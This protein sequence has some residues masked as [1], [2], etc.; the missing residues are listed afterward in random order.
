MRVAAQKAKRRVSRTKTF[1]APRRGWIANENLASSKPEGS[2]LLQNWFPTPTGCRARGGSEKYGTAEVDEPVTSMATYETGNSSEFFAT[3]AT[4]LYPFTTVVDPDVAPAALVT[5][6]TGGDWSW[7]QIT[8]TAGA[9]FLLGVNGADNGLIYDGTTWFPL[10]DKAL[11]RLNFDGQTVN[12]TT[13]TVTGGTSGAT[14]TIFR[15]FD[16][17]ATGYLWLT[18]IVGTF[19]NNEALTGAP[20]AAV[21]DGTILQLTAAI[22]GVDVSDLSYLAL[23]ASRIWAV[24]K[25]T[26][27]AYYLS[28]LSVGGA[29][30]KFPLGGVFKRGGSLL[31]IAEWSLDEGNGLSAS[32]AFVSTK[33]EVAIYG[34][35]DPSDAATWSLRGVYRIGL[36][37]GKDAWIK[38]GGDL[39]IATDIGMVPLSQAVSRD[40]A[41]LSA[42]AVS[43]PIE[44]EWSQAVATR[45]ARPWVCEAWP[46][47][48]MLLV[49]IPPGD[50]DPAGM[51]V[52]NMLTGAWTF[53]TAWDGTCLQLF[54]DRMFFGTDV[55]TVV[56][57][58]VTGSDQG[59]PYVL[60]NVPLFD[61]LKGPAALKT[62]TL[63]R[64]VYR[65]PVE[66]NPLMSGQFDFEVMLPPSPDAS[67]AVGGSVWGAAIW[68]TST[69]GAPA[70]KRT[71][72]KWQSINGSGYACAAASQFTIG[73]ISAPQIEMIRTDVM[74]EM[75]DAVS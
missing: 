55:G 3:T 53:Y 24:K 20:G 43:N 56:E 51:F 45:T 26:L 6:L 4:D 12:F 40:Y 58:E 35:L 19:Q 60:V 28:T 10:F 2:R 65:A 25:D 1:P 42:A 46:T 13:G 71:F 47:K 5:G 38:A 69:W 75:G 9:A 37:L 32:L 16:S 66:A 39:V 8:N 62:L 64:Q 23:H 50:N 63:A 7:Q 44:D 68:G 17:G 57:A 15:V 74:Y 61:D 52:A 27:D 29:A 67:G 30:T 18:D 36:P 70:A 33:G 22:T 11:Y 34:G 31:F 49:A 41:A 73:G 54:G 59:M 72:Q 21:V 48:Q 14:G